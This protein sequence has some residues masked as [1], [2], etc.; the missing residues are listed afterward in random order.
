MNV[1]PMNENDLPR[2]LIEKG[3]YEVEVLDAED[4]ISTSNN[5]MI[6]LKIAIWVGDKIRCHIY[7]YLLDKIPA[8]LRHACDSFGL[9]DKYQSG[10]LCATDFLGRTGK[11]KIGIK[12]DK[13]GQYPDKNIIVDYCIRATKPLSKQQNNDE[14]P[15][16]DDDLPF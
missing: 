9:L 12:I 3:D 11:A 10:N 1:T 15:L 13:N 5:E 8:K 6:A 2:K 4:K 7:D 16:T 14:P